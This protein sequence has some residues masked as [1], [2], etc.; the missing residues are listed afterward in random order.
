MNALPDFR[1]DGQVALVTGAG[2]GIG[3]Q[4]AVGIAASGASVA[5]LDL[6]ASGLA[7]TSRA[8]AEQGGISATYEADVTQQGAV[9]HVVDDLERRLGQLSLAVNAAG[10]ADAMPAHE[11]AADR[12][13][14]LLEVNVTGLFQSCQA[15]GR[16]MLRRGIG[17]IVNIGSI[18]GLVSHSEM[19]QVHYNSSKAAVAHLSRSLA[20]EWADG[21]VRV[22]SLSPGFTLTPMNHR[23][24]VAQMRDQISIKIPLGRFAETAEMVGPVLFLLSPASRYCTGTDLVVDGGYTAL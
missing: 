21:G 22:N 7:A 14:R 16:A 18:S 20:T 23:A 17:S 10:I 19:K 6:S 1:L 15:E 24:E 9:T 8:I 11:L 4:V 3:Q 13:R 12:F 2:S 5:L